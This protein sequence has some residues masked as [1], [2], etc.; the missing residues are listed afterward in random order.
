MEDNKTSPQNINCAVVIPAL[1]PRPDLADFVR[2]LLNRGIPRIIVVNDGSDSSFND[3]FREIGQ[4]E[5]CTVLTHSVN[6][7]KGRALKTAF[8]YFL[9]NCPGLSG[10]VTADA[11][12]QHAVDD[13]CRIGERLFLKQG[14]LIL[15]IRN[16]KD[17][18]VPER[19]LIGNTIT[20][21]IFQLFY[22]Y[23]LSDTQTG[24]RGIPA[25]ELPWVVKLK[26]ER[27]DFEI[28]MLIGVMHHNIGFSTMPIKTLYYDNNSGSHYS[29]IGDSARIF[30]CLVSGLLYDPG[31][32][33]GYII[34]HLNILSSI[35]NIIFRSIRFCA[36]CFTPRY[37]ICHTSET[38]VPAVYIVHHQNLQG[39]L[40]C[41]IWLN[42]PVRLWVLNAFCSCKK[43]F[44]QYY[45]YTFT[46][47]FGMPKILAALAALPLSLLVPGLMNLI[48]AIPVFRGS[49]T[50]ADT[51]RQS[52]LTLTSGKNLLIC[53]DIDYTNKSPH[54]GEM[55]TGFL[56]LEK[57]FIKQTGSHLAFIPL[58]VSKLR[59]C[60]YVGQ[61]VYF[62]IENN[63]KQEKGKVYNS[64]KQEFARLE[65][66]SE[67]SSVVNVPDKD[68]KNR[69][70]N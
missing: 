35:R 15:G 33:A 28:N 20:S 44:H 52:I 68:Y 19:S 38:S 55:Y 24:L 42:M 29:T 53:P 25:S 41:M 27:Y 62:S 46:K 37:K 10:V 60:I 3:I 6:R 11:D 64:L 49:R 12:G 22:G 32:K 51:F 1:N 65:E 5:C 61:A 56:D 57:Y 63:F 4:I 31:K 59:H 30:A 36:R 18:S 26:G 2:E 23:Y 47:R 48:R 16:F 8:S 39:P 21:R 34:S 17:S 7:G 45:D 43:C 67:R 70:I 58:H 14:S 9:R 69:S 50:I 40:K 66:Y 54:M 13:I